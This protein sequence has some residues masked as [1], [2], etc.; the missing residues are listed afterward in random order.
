MIEESSSSRASKV[1]SKVRAMRGSGGGSWGRLIYISVL[2]SVR[3]A[4]SSS[5][6]S[7]EII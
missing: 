1:K 6:M 7:W 4:C 5:E 3:C 2:E